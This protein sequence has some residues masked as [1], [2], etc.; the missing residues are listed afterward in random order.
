MLL[1][2]SCKCCSSS[3]K[4]FTLQTHSIPVFMRRGLSSFFFLT[5]RCSGTDSLAFSG[6]GGLLGLGCCW[7]KMKH[8]AC[9]AN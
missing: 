5:G 3:L 9:Y 1:H 7:G 2:A 6:K 4:V 8:P